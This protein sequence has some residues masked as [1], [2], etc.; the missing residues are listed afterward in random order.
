MTDLSSTERLDLASRLFKTYKKLASDMDPPAHEYV[1]GDGDLLAVMI[2]ELRHYADW[3]GIDFDSA[4]AA[5]NA[6][7]FQNRAGEDHPYSLGAEVEHPERRHG[8]ESPEEDSIFASRGIVTSIY[9]ERDGTQT[10]HVRFLGESDTWPLKNADLR[11]APAF[12]LVAISR[13]TVESLAEAERLLVETGARIRSCELRGTSPSLHDM[14]DRL[15]LSAALAGA[16]GLT[17]PDIRRLLEPQVAT[18]TAEITKPWRPVHASRPNEMAALDFPQPLQR[19][20]EQHGRS[21][22]LRPHTEPAERTHGR[23][24]G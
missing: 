24:P 16:C 1:E 9:P 8:Y 13:G 19:V 22:G 14:A 3:R 11:P 2:S 18:W 20:I 17:A 6:A 12:P 7:Y 5:G 4:V 10:Y 15:M 21:E 23:R